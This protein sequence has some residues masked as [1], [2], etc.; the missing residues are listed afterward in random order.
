MKPRLY[1]FIGFMIGS[2][3]LLLTAVS[4]FTGNEAC[5]YESMP[6]F[7]SRTEF[8]TLDGVAYVGVLISACIVSSIFVIIVGLI[9][10]FLGLQ[11]TMIQSKHNHNSSPDIPD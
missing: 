7:Y 11:I 8:C 4:W 3:A 2:L 9:A 1:L 6:Q 10:K 5:T